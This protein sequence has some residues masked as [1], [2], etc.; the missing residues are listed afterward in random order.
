M[1]TMEFLGSLIAS[2]TSKQDLRVKAG[3][4]INTLQTFTHELDILLA[5][6]P[7]EFAK[8]DPDYAKFVEGLPLPE[9]K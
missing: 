8:L 4:A 3:E 2:S 1:T 6:A 7:A 9:V 5:A